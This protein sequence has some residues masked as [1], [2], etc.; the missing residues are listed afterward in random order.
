[1]SDGL[2]KDAYEAVVVGTGFG[3]AVAACRLAQAGVDVAVLER[4]R[5]FPPGSFPRQRRAWERDQWMEWQ[6]GGPYEFKP[7]NDVLVVQAAG[8]GGGSLVYA[9][10]QMRAPADAFAAGW[11][12]GYSRAALD[13]YY[14]LVAYMLDVRPVADDPATGAPPPKTRLMEAAAARLG[15]EARTFRP[16]LAVRFGDP[17]AGPAPN[18][19]GV[20]QAACVHC[21]EC[22]MGCNVGA[23]NTLDLNYLA[24]AERHGA[25]VAT[26]SEV[27]AVAPDGDGFVVRFRDPAAARAGAAAE[28]AV[29]ARQLFLC[30]GAVGTTELLLRCRDQHRTLPALSPALGRGYSTNG[31]FLA[32]GLG[33]AAPYAATRG[34]TITTACVLDADG[35]AGDAG[36]AAGLRFVLEDGGY[37]HQLARLVPLLHPLRVVALA[38]QALAG[39][40][41][42]RPRPLARALAAAGDA[43]AVLL[44]MGRDRADGTIA[45][46]RGRRRRLRV[47]WDRR[48]NRALAAAQAAAS[49]DF[50]HAL[51]GR[52]AL[53]P[54]TRLFGQPN[55]VHNLG[56][57]RM[58]AGPADGV[59]DAD[60]RVFGYPGLHVFDG[61][62][63]PAAVGV[64]PSHTIAAVAERCVEAAIRRLPGRDGWRAPEAA[65]APRVDAPEDGVRLPAREPAPPAPPPAAPV[66]PPAARRAALRFAEVMRGTVAR[67]GAGRPARLE[68]TVAVD[69]VRAFVADAAHPGRVAGRVFVDGLTGPAGAAVDGGRWHLLVSTADP[70]ERAMTYD[71]PFR[72][73]DQRPWVLRGVKHVRG[74][75]VADFWRATTTLRARIEPAGGGP[76]VAAGTL[77]I[78]ARAVARELASVRAGPAALARFVAFFGA[79]LLRLYAAGRRRP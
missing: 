71:L 19:F 37:A 66:R 44:L 40:V 50:V 27:T 22:D 20:P 61:A 68:L 29:R 53:A 26:R 18:K 41:R 4:G 9:N 1:M 12:P 13:P 33:V 42:R 54:N 63:L 67:D 79:T 57:C 17:A 62:V 28:R 45:L 77:R 52:L 31:D 36:G 15:H 8:Y 38:W 6:Y 56:G 10:V 69:D 59:V 16:N 70:A 24:V 23:K 11:P 39:R 5:R 14:D 49:R 47:R 3:G 60:G 78:G 21:G 43:T 25:D 72:G 35:D 32:F 46:A 73:A 51:G 7:L 34:P 75:R 58:G 74:R 2:R 30:L 65:V 48:T 55:S 76:P 64:N